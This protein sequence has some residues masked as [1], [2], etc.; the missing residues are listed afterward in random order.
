MDNHPVIRLLGGGLVLIV[1]LFLTALLALQ[2]SRDLALWVFGS[3]VKAD[4]VDRWVEQIGDEDEGELQF[5]YYLRYQ[6]T[7]AN[8]QTL[9]GTTTLSVSEWAGGDGGQ[10]DVVY[11]PPYPQHNR[12]DDSRYVPLLAC[13]YVPLILIAGAVLAAGWQLLRP[14]PGTGQGAG[15]T[16]GTRGG[17]CSS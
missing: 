15:K 14:A 10:V 9:T 13:S 7:V 4:V 5:E 11:F 17:S 12:L 2:L 3:E 6:F 8:G 1:A 16:G